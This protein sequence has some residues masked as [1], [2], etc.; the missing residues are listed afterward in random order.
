MGPGTPTTARLE[1]AV[2]RNPKEVAAADAG[3]KGSKQRTCSNIN[4][5]SGFMA[6]AIRANRSS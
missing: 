2:Y 1:F 3:I 6:S 4:F 5:S